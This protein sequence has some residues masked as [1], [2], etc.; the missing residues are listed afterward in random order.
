MDALMDLIADIKAARETGKSDA[1]LAASRNFQ[2]RAQFYLALLSL[3]TPAA[4]TRHRK[5]R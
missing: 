2:R 3:K 4:F 5:Q 1:E